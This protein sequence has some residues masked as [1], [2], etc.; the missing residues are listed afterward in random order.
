MG[1][2]D[3]GSARAGTLIG[4][5]RRLRGAAPFQTSTSAWGSAAGRSALV[6][7]WS[8]TGRAPVPLTEGV[9]VGEYP[10]RCCQ[11]SHSWGESA[12][13]NTTGAFAPSLTVTVSV[14]TSPF[15]R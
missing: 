2:V 10:V 14:A 15:G 12:A 1:L 4:V 8:S 13:R 5:Q 11:L 6:T 9:H 3:F 7:T